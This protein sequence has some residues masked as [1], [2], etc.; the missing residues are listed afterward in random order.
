[1]HVKSRHYWFYKMLGQFDILS[2]VLWLW[3]SRNI[4]KEHSLY[5]ELFPFQYKARDHKLYVEDLT[6]QDE[7]HYTCVLENKYG[8]INSTTELNIVGKSWRHWDFAQTFL[9]ISTSRSTWP[10]N[11]L[12]K[13]PAIG[14]VTFEFRTSL[15]TSLLLSDWSPTVGCICDGSY[16][17]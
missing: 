5:E 1:M 10:S 12:G 3:I 9:R 6:T 14:K 8:K 4:L 16:T 13:S 2:M 7:G 15:G 17:V 11:S